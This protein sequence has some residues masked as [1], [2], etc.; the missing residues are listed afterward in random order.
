MSLVKFRGIAVAVMVATCLAFGLA[1]ATAQDAH[2]AVTPAKAKITK[3]AVSTTKVKVTW[4]GVKSAT[5]YQVR[6]SKSAKMTSAKKYTVKSSSARSK[7]I[8]SLSSYTKYYVQVRAYRVYKGKTYAGSWSTAKAVRT[9]CAHPA[10]KRAYNKCAATCT[11]MGSSKTVCGVCAKVLSTTK[12]PALGHDFEVTA[13]VEPT[14]TDA[15]EYTYACS[16]CSATKTETVEA[17]GHSWSSLGVCERCGARDPKSSL[18][19]DLLLLEYEPS[20]DYLWERQDDGSIVSTNKGVGSSE[21]TFSLTAKA[22]CKVSFDYAV[23]SEEE[24]DCLVISC[25]GKEVTS[26]SGSDEGAFE[27]GLLQGDVLE[28][29]YSKDGSGNEGKDCAW[30]K[31]VAATCVSHVRGESREVVAT[32]ETAGSVG[33]MCPTCGSYVI[34]EEIPALGH[35]W[36]TTTNPATCTEDGEEI[37]TCKRC[38]ETETETIKALGHD[39]AT[40]TNP[41]TCTEGG[42]TI[43]TCSRCS[44][45]E[46]EPIEALG[47]IPT[48]D[49]K[50]KRCEEAIPVKVGGYVT[51]G[52]YEQDNDESNGKEPVEW[53]VLTTQDGKALLLSRYALDRHSFNDVAGETSWAN[54]ELRTWLNNDFKTAA[55]SESETSRVVESRLGTDGVTTNDSVFVLSDIEKGNYLVS[56][57]SA[58]CTA[59]AYARSKGAKEWAG[60]QNYYIDGVGTTMWWLR[61]GGTTGP[62]Y[63]MYVDCS[64]RTVQNGKLALDTSSRDAAAV[65]PAIWVDLS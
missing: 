58:L 20:G 5:G 32:C 56:Q 16:R 43:S 55:F 46:R 23:S 25:N 27:R 29:S 28:V 15:G 8:G 42:E 63:A 39:L 51:F 62:S 12:V 37:S 49:G 3:T 26:A 48:I 50:C 21:C 1:L 10:S 45:T 4:A 54:C 9:L 24:W 14:C 36:D 38:S 65:R 2:A 34:E 64:G 60:T 31:N 53:L 6:I 40:T 33:F 61:S 7:T 59:T 19:P 13:A 30:I 18:F 11:E 52:S 35:D 44:Y 57:D 17:L 22:D 47:H 41:A